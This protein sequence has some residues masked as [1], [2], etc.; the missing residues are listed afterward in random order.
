MDHT[1]ALLNELGS[2]LPFEVDWDAYHREVLRRLAHAEAARKRRSVWLTLFGALSGAAAMLLLTH[3]L[4]PSAGPARVEL[5]ARVMA[6]APEPESKAQG[7]VRAIRTGSS[8]TGIIRAIINPAEQRTEDAKPFTRRSG[9]S[10][11]RFDG[12]SAPES[13]DAGFI[14]AG[15]ARR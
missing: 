6:D 3:A 8:G 12:F 4:T 15:H 11:I 7:Y 1:G 13:S 2:G 9:T 10:E 5:A 14:A